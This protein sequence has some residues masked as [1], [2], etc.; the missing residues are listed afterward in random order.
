MATVPV[1]FEAYLGVQRNLKSP[2]IEKLVTK[3]GRIS[4]PLYQLMAFAGVVDEGELVL[5][6]ANI[7]SSRPAM[8]FRGL[9]DL[10]HSTGSNGRNR[11]FTF[12]LKIDRKQINNLL[13]EYNSTLPVENAPAIDPLSEIPEIKKVARISKKVKYSPIMLSR[14]SK[15]IVDKVDKL[16]ISDLRSSSADQKEQVFAEV[17]IRLLKSRH[18]EIENDNTNDG[19]C[20]SGTHQVP[21]NLNEVRLHGNN[22][23]EQRKF[24]ENIALAVSGNL[25]VAILEASTGLSRLTVEH[26][27]EM[28]ENFNSDVRNADDL[29]PTN[30]VEDSER[31]L[32]DTAY[33]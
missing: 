23:S 6:E 17:L 22:A 7:R 11:V 24:L 16:F 12:D 30:P 19:C 21:C 20:Y 31:V 4:I 33:C 13:I 9:V 8:G 32:L 26:G 1:V 25:S 29:L 15:G 2:A 18:H 10:S 28:R 3:F 14:Y 27:R 5:Y